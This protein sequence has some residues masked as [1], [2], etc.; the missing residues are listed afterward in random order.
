[1]APEVFK[2]NYNER[3]DIWSCGVILFL[4]LSGRVPFEARNA[5]LVEEKIK[6]GRFTFRDGSWKST[7]KEVREFITQ[8]LE[9]NVD[10]RLTAEQALEHPWIKM[11]VKER[12]K[13]KI[14][15]QVL[16]NLLN[17][18]SKKKLQEAIWV[19]MVSQF[20]GEED[21][22][23]LMDIFESLDK[24]KNGNLDKAEILTGKIEK[25]ILSSRS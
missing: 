15:T 19:Y 24:D 23:K 20:G 22:K 13:G 16:T 25:L 21:K 11:H 5:S 8:M 14:G 7:T 9:K 4:L 10:K 3:C 2:G 17:F 18:N 1:M 12:D 6:A